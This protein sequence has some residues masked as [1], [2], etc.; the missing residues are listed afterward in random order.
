MALPTLVQTK[1]VRFIAQ[2]ARGGN[3]NTCRGLFLAHWSS[4]EMIRTIR[5]LMIGIL[6]CVALKPLAESFDASIS[7]LLNN[8]MRRNVSPA[9]K[10]TAL[11]PLP[12]VNRW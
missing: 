3:G 2:L 10:N 5:P 11:A 8:P 12:A 4:P 9:H 7:V 6:A 1:V